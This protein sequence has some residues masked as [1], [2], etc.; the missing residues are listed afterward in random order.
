MHR[1]PALTVNIWQEH[2]DNTWVWV[3]G[4]VVP[5]TEVS[6]NQTQLTRKVNITNEFLALNYLKDKDSNLFSLNFIYYIASI[7]TYIGST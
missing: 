3:Y 2:K 1:Q 4:E 7:T 6:A 5:C